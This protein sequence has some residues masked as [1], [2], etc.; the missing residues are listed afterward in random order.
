MSSHRII[1][2]LILILCLGCIAHKTKDIKVI[3]GD[4]YF[5]FFRF[6]NFYGQPDS[7]VRLFTEFADTANRS[8]LDSEGQSFLTMYDALKKEGLLYN[9]Y[10]QL[11]TSAHSRITL[12]LNKDDYYKIAPTN[13]QHLIDSR[14][15]IHIK[16]EVR[17]LSDSLVYCNR[18]LNIDT[19]DG[20]TKNNSRKLNI[21][22]YH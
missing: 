7:I 9:P 13:Y 22:D 10:I 16:A 15:K 19:L 4:L 5:G 11:Q 12:F 2:L 20:E 17:Y 1:I 6:D 14:K 8:A 3:E 21:T 18:L